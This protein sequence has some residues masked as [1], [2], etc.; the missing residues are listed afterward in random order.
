MTESTVQLPEKTGPRDESI[1]RLCRQICLCRTRGQIAQA[2]RLEAVLHNQVS[3]DFSED[4]LQDIF[5][6]EQRRVIEALMLAEVLGPLLTEHL[7]AA[8]PDPARTHAPAARSSQRPAT[9]DQPLGIADLIE[10]MLVQERT[11]RG[12]AV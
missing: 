6:A 11:T 3:A 2:N 5:L 12:H 4:T 8:A 9:S 7:T 1:A 10:G